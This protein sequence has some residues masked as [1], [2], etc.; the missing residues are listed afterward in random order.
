MNADFE[1]LPRVTQQQGAGCDPSKLK[2]C[3][4]TR[5]L[6]ERTQKRNGRHSFEMPAVR[7]KNKL[8]AYIFF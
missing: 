2:S 5:E 6:V 3:D 8:D 7:S 4:V 1:H